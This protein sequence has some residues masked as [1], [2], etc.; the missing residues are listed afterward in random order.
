MRKSIFLVSTVLLL[1]ACGSE[2]SS[3]PAA[4]GGAGGDGGTGGA[5]GGAAGS[6]GMAGT[7]GE[8]GT[9]GAAGTA[10][11]AGTAGT[12]PDAGSGGS[13]AGGTA[14]TGVGGTAG[15]GGAGTGGGGTGGTSGSGGTSGTGGTT[16]SRTGP[17][18]RTTNGILTNHPQFQFTGTGDLVITTAYFLLTR[19]SSFNSLQIWGDIENRGTKNLCI[20]LA[21]LAIGGVDILTV[22]D[23]PAY[24]VSGTVTSA[25]VPPNGKAAFSSIENEVAGTILDGSPT[26]VY[27][28]TA[29]DRPAALRHPDEPAI[30]QP[31]VAAVSRGWGV[32]GSMQ[33]RAN[34]I[35]NFGIDIYARDSSGVLFDT[36]T[37]FPGNLATLAP[38][39]T[40]TFETSPAELGVSNPVDGPFEGFELYTS[41][42]EGMAR[43][44]STSAPTED[45]VRAEQR[46]A[47]RTQVIAARQRLRDLRLVANIR[48]K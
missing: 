36:A 41:F 30:L 1:G 5:D 26:V 2:D 25:C 39:T 9:A 8:A 38:N 43:S 34:Y 27:S 31:K 32:T 6:A 35:Y 18:S 46:A 23:G 48:G 10:G 17:V 37:A 40:M 33:T 15:S 24:D 14:G 11:Q 4:A 28:F 22:V 47:R 13:A 20:P 42:I 29:L 44:A 21:D 12:G 45:E 7:A 19:L 16:P 3:N